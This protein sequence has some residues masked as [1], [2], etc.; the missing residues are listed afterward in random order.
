LVMMMMMMSPSHVRNH[1]SRGSAKDLL[2]AK[3]CV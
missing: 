2:R 3:L 1:E